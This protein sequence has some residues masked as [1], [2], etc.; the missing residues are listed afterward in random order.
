MEVKFCEASKNTLKF[1]FIIMDVL[2]TVD[3]ETSA[4]NCSDFQTLMCVSHL[5]KTQVYCNYGMFKTF[6]SL[7]LL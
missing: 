3:V 6:P 4:K 1:P 7:F 5:H 2:V